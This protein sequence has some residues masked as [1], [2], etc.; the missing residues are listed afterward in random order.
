MESSGFEK[1][2]P[3][4][5]KK[6]HTRKAKRPRLV[7]RLFFGRPMQYSRGIVQYCKSTNFDRYKSLKVIQAVRTE[8]RTM[9]NAISPFLN[10]V[11]TGDN[12]MRNLGSYA[13]TD[14]MLNA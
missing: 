5:W 10:F 3:K 9:A 2:T 12:K 11:E 8:G 13:F 4:Q 1:N 6:V 14:N 7:I